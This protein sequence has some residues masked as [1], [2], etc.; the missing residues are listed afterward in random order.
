MALKA[1]QTVSIL[2]AIAVVALISVYKDSFRSWF[3]PE[4]K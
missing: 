1:T 2:G 3:S 4:K